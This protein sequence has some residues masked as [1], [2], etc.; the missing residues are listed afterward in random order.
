MLGHLS[1]RRFPAS[2]T[3]GSFRKR[4]PTNSIQAECAQVRTLAFLQTF[5]HSNVLYI[6]KENLTISHFLDHGNDTFRAN[7]TKIF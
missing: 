6:R 1:V 5:H 7:I 4:L 2:D 3:H